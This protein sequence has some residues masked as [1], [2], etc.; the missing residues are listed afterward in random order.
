MEPWHLEFNIYMKYFMKVLI[1]VRISGIPLENWGITY[2][3]VIINTLGKV[4]KSFLYTN[5]LVSNTYPLMYIYVHLSKCIFDS[6]VMKKGFE[7]KHS[8][9]ENI[10]FHYRQYFEHVHVV[11]ACSRTI[12]SYPSRWK[13]YTSIVDYSLNLH[14]EE[15]NELFQQILMFYLLLKT[16]PKPWYSYALRCKD[17]FLRRVSWKFKWI[18]E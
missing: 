1:C 15:M 6:I 13:W 10:P 11:A 18:H 2:L 3:F 14:W 12:S 9:N 4:V 5:N 16:A 7:N 17:P 8:I